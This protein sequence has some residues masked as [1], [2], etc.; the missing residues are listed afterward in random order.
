MCNISGPQDGFY[1]VQVKSMCVN[2]PKNIDDD[3][4]RDD[5]EPEDRPI[6][7]PTEM[8]YFI[9][10]CVAGEFARMMIDASPPISCPL[11]SIAPED[12]TIL[13]VKLEECIG[14]L[15]AYFRLEEMDSPDVKTL[16]QRMPQLTM[17]RAI[18][19]LG[20][21]LAKIRLHRPHMF[22]KPPPPQFA[23][24]RGACVDAARQMIMISNSM[25]HIQSNLAL[26]R[27]RISFVLHHYFMAVLVLALDLCFN[28]FPSDR[29]K[30]ERRKELRNACKLLEDT[31]EVSTVA[32]GYL[33]PLMDVLRKHRISLHDPEQRPARS[34]DV[35]QTENGNTQSARYNGI[36]MPTD[37]PEQAVSGSMGGFYDV[38]SNNM[39]VNW[40]DVLEFPSFETTPDWDQLFAD[41]DSTYTL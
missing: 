6:S 33:V 9:V 29:A 20:I 18:I 22:Q 24:C 4:L 39:N 17:Q 21:H 7:Q 13:E 37:I 35:R 11:T 19:N 40:Q 12:F 1:S 8:S 36:V 30:G 3:D 38:M 16:H 41:I 32:A 15:P 31:Q 2:M 14:S 5:I 34:E 27:S 10:R 26:S 23:H 25:N 28:D